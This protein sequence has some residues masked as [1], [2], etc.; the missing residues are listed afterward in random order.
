MIREW[1]HI[2]QDTSKN[3]HNIAMHHLLRVSV[4]GLSLFGQQFNTTSVELVV[5]I[6]NQTKYELKLSQSLVYRRYICYI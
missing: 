3:Q 4:L 1:L 2:V 5:S 6:L